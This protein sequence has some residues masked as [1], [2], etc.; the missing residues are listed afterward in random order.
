MTE[1][2]KER[3]KGKVKKIVVLKCDSCGKENRIREVNLYQHEVEAANNNNGCYCSKCRPRDRKGFL[4]NIFAGECFIVYPK[5]IPVKEY[6]ERQEGAERAKEILRRA[7]EQLNCP[8]PKYLSL[9]ISRQSGKG[10]EIKKTTNT[11]PKDMNTRR[12]IMFTTKKT[13]KES[14][15]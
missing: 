12:T 7:L 14:N 11:S 10:G 3:N 6:Q 9:P 15:P 2:G 13:T 4:Y 1:K 5:V 8:P